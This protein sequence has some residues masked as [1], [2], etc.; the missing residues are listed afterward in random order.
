MNHA[1]VADDLAV[2]DDDPQVLSIALVEQ[3]RSF[4]VRTARAGRAK[5]ARQQG[6]KLLPFRRLKRARSFQHVLLSS[7]SQELN[8]NRRR[9]AGLRAG[10]SERP[11][12][13][14]DRER[15]DVVAVLIRGQ[16]QLSGGIEVKIAGDLA[17][18]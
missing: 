3:P 11:A 9:H 10:R 16:E 8:A 15:D 14:V 4:Q 5:S 18:S 6:V 2:L 1:G 12:L 13:G 17:T 7:R